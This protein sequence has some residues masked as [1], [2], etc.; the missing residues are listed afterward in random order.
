[1]TTKAGG[2][3]ACAGTEEPGNYLHVRLNEYSYRIRLC[4]VSTE[5]KPVSII[6]FIIKQVK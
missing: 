1:M 2:C 4:V 3:T 6:K 5:D